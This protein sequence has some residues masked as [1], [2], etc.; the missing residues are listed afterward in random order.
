MDQRDR[1]D[2]PLDDENEGEGN[3]SADRAYREGAEE[4]V[5]THDVER[6]AEQARRDIERDPATY[7]EARRESLEHIAEEDPEVS[8]PLERQVE[9]S[10]EEIDD[11]TIESKGKEDAFDDEADFRDTRAGIA[12]PPEVQRVEKTPDDVEDE[13]ARAREEKDKKRKAA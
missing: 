1:N 12:P 7:E 3:K 5:E 10:E 8:V 4:F 13:I 2:R 6:L 9:G 11:E